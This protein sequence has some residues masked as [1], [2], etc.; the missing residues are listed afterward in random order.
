MGETPERLVDQKWVV[1]RAASWQNPYFFFKT[2]LSG[3]ALV[4][5]HGKVVQKQ[6]T[7]RDERGKR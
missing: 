5:N 4:S 2:R 6:F 3:W 1:F 7:V